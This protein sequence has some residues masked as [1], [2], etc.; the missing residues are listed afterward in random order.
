MTP[1]EV[2]PPSAIRC[3]TTSGC[4]SSS[5]R[6][7]VAHASVL[8]KIE[9]ASGT[10]SLSRS[11]ELRM[12]IEPAAGNE[13]AALAGEIEQLLAELRIVT[14]LVPDIAGEK[15]ALGAVKVSTKGD[16]IVMTAPWSYEALDRGFA[17]LAGLLH[18]VGSH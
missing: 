4:F 13:A 11:P 14:L 8:R 16:R 17:R 7:V 9:R 3:W 2:T 18:A 5:R 12:E 1:S 10:F 15:G 6:A